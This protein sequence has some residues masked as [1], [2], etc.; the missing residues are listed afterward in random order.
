MSDEFKFE[1]YK[2]SYPIN[3][4]ESD[5]DTP[6]LVSKLPNL[7]AAQTRTL[8][9]IYLKPYRDALS[10]SW[11]VRESKEEARHTH[12][13]HDIVV[14]R[15][16]WFP[17]E[18]VREHS[19][20]RGS[21]GSIF[22]RSFDQ[23]PSGLDDDDTKLVYRTNSFEDTKYPKQFD[24]LEKAQAYIDEELALDEAASELGAVVEY[25]D[26]MEC[27]CGEYGSISKREYL[28]HAVDIAKLVR[29]E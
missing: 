2:L 9:D 23:K 5:S 19:D 13:G 20:Q 17:P 10:Y 4:A 25:L 21:W 14:E 24:S 16:Y 22:S 28:R 7:F 6:L 26:S 1:T 29:A 15:D 11:R 18:K 27:S 8:Q 12:R 3:E